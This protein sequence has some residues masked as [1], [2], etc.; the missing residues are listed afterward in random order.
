MNT[1]GDRTRINANQ[2][3]SQSDSASRQLATKPFSQFLSLRVHSWFIFALFAVKPVPDGLCSTSAMYF[4]VADGSACQ[5]RIERMSPN[6]ANGMKKIG[7]HFQW[8]VVM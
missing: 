4:R 8:P 5:M 7:H 2:R 6:S 3:E 1:N